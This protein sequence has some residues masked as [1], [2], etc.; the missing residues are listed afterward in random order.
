MRAKRERRQKLTSIGC[1][2]VG[3]GGTTITIYATDS[4]LLCVWENENCPYDFKG[5]PDADNVAPDEHNVSRI[6]WDEVRRWADAAP[7]K[8]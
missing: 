7:R 5:P 8:R 1:R 2:S 3:P 4:G 6:P